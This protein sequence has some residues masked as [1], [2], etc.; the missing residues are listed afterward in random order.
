MQRTK[1][2]KLRNKN[3]E[4]KIREEAKKMQFKYDFYFDTILVAT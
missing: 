1:I 4:M 2:K 3:K